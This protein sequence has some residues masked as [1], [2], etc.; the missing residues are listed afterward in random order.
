MFNILKTKPEN[1][2]SRVLSDFSTN[3][4]MSVINLLLCIPLG[5]PEEDIN[6]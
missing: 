6:E 4:K 5:D 2:I 3:K 1:P